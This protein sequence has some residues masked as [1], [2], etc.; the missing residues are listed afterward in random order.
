MTK[1]RFIADVDL[2]ED[3]VTVLDKQELL[4]TEFDSEL[5]LAP[6]EDAITVIGELN[7][8]YCIAMML[9]KELLHYEDEQDVDYWIKEIVEDLE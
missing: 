9:K 7:K 8:W 6:A 5:I 3:I 4:K 2:K 1:S